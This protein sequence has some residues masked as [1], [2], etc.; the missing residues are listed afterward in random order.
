MNK[1]TFLN[2]DVE[3]NVSEEEITLAPPVK[4]FD[5]AKEIAKTTV[6]D[7]KF[8]F[9]L[10]YDANQ[11][12][13]LLSMLGM[14]GAIVEDDDDDGHVLAT[15]MNMTQ[16]AFI[17]RLDCVERVKTDEGEVRN[18]FLM[19]EAAQPAATMAAVASAAPMEMGTLQ[20]EPIMTPAANDGIAVASASAGARSA[21]GSC[22]A[23]NSSMATA[24]EINV[25]SSVSG[26]INCPGANHWFKFTVPQS[27][28]YTIYTT[29][30]LDT[31][32][33]LYNASGEVLATNDDYNGKVNFRIT[34][35][36]VQNTVY[37]IKVTASN[38][39]TGSDRKSVV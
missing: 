17:K 5:E 39:N 38:M 3:T 14:V 6:D 9:M 11:K 29:G 25:E 12:E 34:A 22:S 8:P 15:M 33:T 28:E 4:L 2:N 35:T 13:H 32:G 16:L 21:C 23:S 36:P 19:E 30:S 18:P 24:R 27:K 37:Y 7:D 20:T 26:S 31:E 1:E 10:H